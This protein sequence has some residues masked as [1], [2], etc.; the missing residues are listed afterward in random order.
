MLTKFGDRRLIS[1]K[2]WAIVGHGGVGLGGVLGDMGGGE[3]GIKR[4]PYLSP[5]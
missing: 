1:R 2:A 3:G 5:L 4:V